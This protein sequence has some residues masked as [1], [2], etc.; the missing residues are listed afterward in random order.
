MSGQGAGAHAS[1]GDPLEEVGEE[2]VIRAAR[3]TERDQAR[4][5]WRGE[6]R[7]VAVEMTSKGVVGAPPEPLFPRAQQV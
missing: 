3:V 2:S 4:A 7:Q 6:V 1:E 5:G